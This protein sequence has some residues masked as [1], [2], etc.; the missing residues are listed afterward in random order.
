MNWLEKFTQ[1]LI[2]TRNF[3]LLHTKGVLLSFGFFILLISG[4]FSA[5]Y[6]WQNQ[7]QKEAEAFFEVMFSSPKENQK[8]SD[9]FTRIALL[10]KIEK[11]AKNTFFKSF[12]LLEAAE[13]AKNEKAE[14][15]MKELMAK[16][17]TSLDDSLLQDIWILKLT[18]MYREMG[19]YD[20]ALA[21][22]T[23]INSPM[24]EDLQLLTLG[25]IYLDK[26][27][28]DKAR[29]NLQ[30]LLQKFPQSTLRDLAENYL[31]FTN[32]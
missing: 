29:V 15:K 5:V 32:L 22:L 8:K 20:S 19:D 25:K 23:K 11:E 18:E 2:R 4:G 9:P 21:Q 31:S 13:V 24:F 6:W 10:E 7:K 14:Q 16:M 27:D 12:L 17:P 3:L 1:F 26:K 28:K 30:N